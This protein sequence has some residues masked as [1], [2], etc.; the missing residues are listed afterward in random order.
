MVCGQDRAELGRPA[1]AGVAV[2]D[3]GERERVAE[4]LDLGL[5]GGTVVAGISARSVIS[6]N[7]IS[8]EV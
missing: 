8:E 3:V 2:G 1:P 6:S 5:V 7:D 4:A